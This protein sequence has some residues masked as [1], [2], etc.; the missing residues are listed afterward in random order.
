MIWG[1]SKEE[2]SEMVNGM[3]ISNYWKQWLGRKIFYSLKYSTPMAFE[4]SFMAYMY[5]YFPCEV[6]VIFIQCFIDPFLC[7][8][9]DFQ[10]I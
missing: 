10:G 9:K 8:Y 4:I 3:Y 1:Y 2:Y 6:F 7:F 5:I